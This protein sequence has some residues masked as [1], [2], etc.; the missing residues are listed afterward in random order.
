MTAPAAGRT[1]GFHD[2][3]ESESEAGA[4]SPRSW[5]EAG[6]VLPRAFFARPATDVAPE[7]LGCVISNQTSAGL[8]AAVIVEV[9]AYAGPADP[10]SHAYRGKTARNAVMFGEPGHAYV[11]FTYGMHFCVNLV[12]QPAG[13][14]AAVL[15]RAGY[16]VAG[17]ELATSRR[18]VKRRDADSGAAAQRAADDGVA[19][20]RA[21]RKGAASGLRDLARGP[22]RLCQA[23]GIDRARNGADACDPASP[24]LVTRLAGDPDLGS[25][26]GAIVAGPRIGVSQGG[27]TP[28][29]FWVADNNFV[30]N[31]RPHS[32][33]RR[34]A[35][36]TADPAAGSPESPQSPERA[37]F[38]V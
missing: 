38:P 27:E 3:G 10:A 9:E 14:A 12:C 20:R 13:A 26:R 29:R 15:I 1:D 6:S 2:R 22:A 33:R 11:Y 7:L 4:D 8:V 25:G 36:G 21:A 19:E 35:A 34:P 16:V 37:N 31:Y 30:S 23:L 17:I 5:I 32:P 24:L 18:A 28:W